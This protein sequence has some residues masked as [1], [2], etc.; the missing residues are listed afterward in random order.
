MLWKK[1]ENI[2]NKSVR[3]SATYEN[4]KVIAP[5]GVLKGVLQ[6]PPLKDA[7]SEEHTVNAVTKQ[8][9]SS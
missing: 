8:P 7:S 5:R 3:R 1:E 2:L 9:I 4:Q 6:V